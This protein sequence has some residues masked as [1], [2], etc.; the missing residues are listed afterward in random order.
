MERR[1]VR[2]GTG[3][4]H[5]GEVGDETDGFT[6]RHQVLKDTFYVVTCLLY[7]GKSL[8]RGPVMSWLLL[9]QQLSTFFW[10][11]QT[12]RMLCFVGMRFLSQLVR[13]AFVA[14]TQPWHC[15]NDWVFW[16]PVEPRLY[17]QAGGWIWGYNKHLLHLHCAIYGRVRASVEE[18]RGSLSSGAHTLAAAHPS[19]K[20]P[21]LTNN[22][23]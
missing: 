11:G 15:L 13:S 21:V 6:R 22:I 8:S 20:D 16:V 17:R 23:Q 1:P 4:G 12:M 7:V 3:L 18:K 5:K 10:N 14:G 9:D 2:R 19:G